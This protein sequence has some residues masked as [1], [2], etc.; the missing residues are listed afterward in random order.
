M[1]VFSRG[2]GASGKKRDQSQVEGVWVR[3]STS[4]S[5]SAR[6]T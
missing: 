3:F 1:M 5:M 6:N 2:G 4:P